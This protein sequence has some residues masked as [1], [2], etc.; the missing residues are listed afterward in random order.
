MPGVALGVRTG[1]GKPAKPKPLLM[2]WIFPC[3]V[4]GSAATERLARDASVVKTKRP[5]CSINPGWITGVE[6]PEMC[7]QNTLRIAGNGHLARH[8]NR[9]G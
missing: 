1:R 3:A 8:S 4:A 2:T 5:A 7:D 9:R 6:S